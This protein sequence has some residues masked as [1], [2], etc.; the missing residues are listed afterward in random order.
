MESLRT[1]YANIIIAYNKEK[2]I[3]ETNEEIINLLMKKIDKLESK[4]KK[5]SI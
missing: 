4:A 5:V 1:K 3:N 2:Q